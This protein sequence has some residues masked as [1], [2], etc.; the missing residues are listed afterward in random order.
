MIAKGSRVSIHYKLTVDG[1]VVDAS[2]GREPLEYTH[3]E[4]TIVPGLEDALAGLKAGDKKSVV[5]DPGAGYGERVD[6][7]KT[8][9]PKDKFGDPS[10]LRVGGMVRGE[11][12]GGP[13]QAVIT[14]VGENDVE[15]DLNHPLAGK[16]LN[17]EIEIVS[18]EP[19]A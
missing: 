6:D 12:G 1:G 17:F 13:F 16:T 14:E 10:T 5:V 3:G 18:V 7:A 9:V 19:A 15:L 11:S 4:G 2:E 8:R